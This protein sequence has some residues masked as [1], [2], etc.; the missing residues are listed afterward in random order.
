MTPVIKSVTTLLLL[1][2][3]SLTS[4]CITLLPKP[5]KPP[6]VV[7]MRADPTLTRVPNSA[8]FS[9]GVGVPTMSPALASNKVAVRSETGAYAYVDMLILSAPAPQIIQNVVLE[10]FDRTG[11]ARAAVRALTVARP[12]YEVHFD[13]NAFE[14]T[15]P[16]G[17]RP[18]I[19]RIEAAVR[20]VD[21][22]TGQPI[23][24]TIIAVEVPAPR[25]DRT[26]PAKALEAA[27]RQMAV[28]A[29]NWSIRNATPFYASRAASAT[30]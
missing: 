29:M 14:V 13:I 21:A 11:A 25:G 26:V 6:T 10:T 1:A 8:P 3:M 24:A 15:E 12:D 27:T 17:R 23:T 30:K 16:E 5:G 9:I 19:A 22:S 28:Q 20:L 2:A 18:G 7:T 4:G